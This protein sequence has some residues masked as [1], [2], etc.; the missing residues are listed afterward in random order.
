[1]A[2]RFLCRCERG[3]HFADPGFRLPLECNPGM[4]RL[5]MKLKTFHL[6]PKITAAITTL[7]D[8]VLLFGAPFFKCDPACLPD[9]C[10]EEPSMHTFVV[11]TNS[12][13]F[14]F[15]FVPVADLVPRFEDWA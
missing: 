15:R 8:W 10:R 6:Q 3:Y 12:V 2:G 9:C 4:L 5:D 11:P 14:S 7:S 1:M 13:G